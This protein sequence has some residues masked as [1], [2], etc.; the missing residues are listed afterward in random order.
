MKFLSLFLSLVSLGSLLCPVLPAEE[1]PKKSGGIEELVAVTRERSLEVR[2]KERLRTLSR[3]PW[4]E[5]GWGETLWSLAALYQNE[6]FDEGNE[7]LL[8]NAK[9]YTEAAISS[10]EE[11]FR[12]E[13]YPEKSPWAYFALPGDLRIVS[14]FREGSPH[15]SGRLKPETE[16]AMK[17]ALW[18]WG[19]GKSRVEE[20]SLDNLLALQGP[21]NHDLTLRPGYYLVASILKDDPVYA[22]RLFDDGK[23][24]AQHFAAYKNLLSAPEGKP[25]S[26]SHSSVSETSSYQAPAAAIVLRNLEFPLEAPFVIRNRVLGEISRLGDRD[27]S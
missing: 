10:G 6:K 16:A 12:P 11:D 17:E 2:E 5:G 23:T 4:P 19:K 24:A 27:A 9:A 21:E 8:R 20:A 18:I 25:A 3:K 22:E 15:F 26:S 13:S 1:L 14:L 7:S